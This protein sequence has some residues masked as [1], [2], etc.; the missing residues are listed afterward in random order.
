MLYEIILEIAGPELKCALEVQGLSD[1]HQLCDT[2][3]SLSA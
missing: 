1:I 2:L 3:F